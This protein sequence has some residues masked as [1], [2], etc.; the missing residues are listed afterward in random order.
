VAGESD[1][2]GRRPLR[3]RSWRTA[4]HVSTFPGARGDGEVA[5]EVVGAGPEAVL[6]AGPVTAAPH[7]GRA[8]RRGRAGPCGVGHGGP[9]DGWWCRYRSADWRD[10][11]TAAGAPAP[12]GTCRPS[13]PTSPWLTTPA[14]AAAAA[15]LPSRPT[16]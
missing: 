4:Y 8:G 10:G 9:R 6:A 14:A 16:V 15:P 1:R 2:T 12:A 11:A 3:G 13:G 5:E 7:S